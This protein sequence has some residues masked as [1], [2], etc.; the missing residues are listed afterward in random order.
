MI[1][2]APF[3]YIK[4]M[5]EVLKFAICS[6]PSLYLNTVLDGIS[7]FVRDFSFPLNFVSANV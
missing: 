2:Y 5:M 1:R 6:K 7:E 3:S 4:V